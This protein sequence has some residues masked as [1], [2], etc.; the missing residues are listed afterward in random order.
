[1]NVEEGLPWLSQLSWKASAPE[2]QKLIDYKD[3]AGLLSFLQEHFAF[4]VI[5]E[6][7]Q[8]HCL[9]DGLS[10]GSKPHHKPLLISGV[11]APD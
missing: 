3:R 2:P 10:H 1:M 5:R 6:A 8:Q 11:R 9:P 7:D 4:H